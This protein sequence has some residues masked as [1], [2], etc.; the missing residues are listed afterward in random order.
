MKIV[1]AELAH[2]KVAR[3]VCEFDI[4]DVEPIDQLDWKESGKLMRPTNVRVIVTN[5]NVG[6]LW[7][8]GPRINKGGVEGAPITRPWYRYT[9]GTPTWV[10]ELRKQAL[11]AYVAEHGADA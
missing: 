9:D 10:D 7:I 3:T 5:G 8:T 6:T 4:T 2:T 11:A 1:K